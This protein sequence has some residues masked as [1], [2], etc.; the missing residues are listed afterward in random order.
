MK[1]AY[2]IEVKRCCASCEHKDA[3]RLMNSRWCKKHERKVKA[4][5]VCSLWAM[6]RG[7][8]RAGLSQGDV[9]DKDT[10]EVLY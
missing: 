3:T 9:R 10:K 4:D 8:C 5:G 1:N 7:L 6:S 2:G